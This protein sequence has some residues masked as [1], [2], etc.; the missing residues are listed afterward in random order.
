MKA[1]SQYKEMS[2][3]IKWLKEV[4]IILKIKWSNVIKSKWSKI[5]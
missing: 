5:M 1:L 3:I 4:L 2:I